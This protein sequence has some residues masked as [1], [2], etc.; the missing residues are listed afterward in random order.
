ARNQALFEQCLRSGFRH[1]QQAVDAASAG[2]T[3]LVLPGLY[4]EE[5]SLAPLSAECANL[6]AP[7]VDSGGSG[8]DANDRHRASYQV[9]SYEQ[10]VSCP[11]NQNLVAVL[12][13]HDLQIE[14]TGED[15]TDVRSEEHTSE[16][17]SREKLVCRILLEKKKN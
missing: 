17:Q 11:H 16:L 9:L 6:D 4:Q 8:K 2:T 10:Q 15:P 12:G 7:W 5:P 13:K 14:G 3:I 1:L